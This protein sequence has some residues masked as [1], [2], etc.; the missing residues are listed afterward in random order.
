M[1]TF[2]SNLS[3]KEY[4]KFVETYPMA[5]FMQEY[6]WSNIKDNW[7]NFH[8]GLFK[9]KKLVGVCLILVKKV[10]RNIKMFYI[11]RGYLIDFTNYDDL[12]AM[13]DNIK[14]LAKERNAYVVKIDPNFCISDNSFK[15]ILEM[16][17]KVK[18]LKN[19]FLYNNRFSKGFK[20]KIKNY[21]RKNSLYNVRLY[22]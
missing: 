19:I 6:N 4:D 2:T 8:C 14:K 3:K 20:N 15:I 22:L 13:T 16:I 10:F 7:G 1:Y 9:D 5:S 12:K 11:P 17:K 18:G 21:D